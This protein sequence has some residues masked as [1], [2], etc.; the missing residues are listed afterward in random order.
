MYIAFIATHRKDKMAA[1]WMI[2]TYTFVAGVLGTIA[3]GTTRMF[4]VGR[5]R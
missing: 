3:S 4:N 1:F 5:T 2:A